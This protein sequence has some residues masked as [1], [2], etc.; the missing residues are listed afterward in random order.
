[1]KV[2]CVDVDTLEHPATIRRTDWERKKA[3]GYA[4]LGRPTDA[5]APGVWWLENTKQGTTLVFG[6]TY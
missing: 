4:G 5:S 3:H 1:M 2:D 6:T